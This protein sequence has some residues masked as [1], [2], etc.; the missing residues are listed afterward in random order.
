M[1]AKSTVS[2]Y[3]TGNRQYMKFCSLHSIPDPYPAMENSILGFI[4]YLFITNKAV[5]TIHV[6]LYAIR[7][8]QLYTYNSDPLKGK[9]KIEAMIKAIK[10]L[11][12]SNRQQR[13]PI[14][15]PLLAKIKTFLNLSVYDQ[16][17]LWAAL[18]L[19][20]YGLLRT[21]ELAQDIQRSKSNDD[22][23]LLLVNN[24]NVI[25]DTHYILTIRASKTDPYQ[26]GADIHY[27]ANN[28]PT[29]PINAIKPLLLHQKDSCLPLLALSDNKPLTTKVLIQGIRLLIK[30][31]E[32]KHKLGLEHNNF[33]GYSLRR[34]G[35]TSL[36][37]AGLSETTI[38]TMG[39]WRSYCFRLYVDTPLYVLKN[40]QVSM[41]TLGEGERPQQSLTSNTPA[42]W[43]IESPPII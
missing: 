18:V 24:I 34:G 42:F 1:L 29:C 35:A 16:Q 21:S 11:K 23:R 7:Y 12:K 38:K 17:V 4:T 14:T 20:V 27:F 43:D 39:R 5:S 2:T 40:A 9:H 6:Y 3:A 31:V 10:R 32:A 41:S 25:S 30:S 37:E 19:G 36:Y 22:N 33:S 8:H 15:I 28:T 13:I 26:M